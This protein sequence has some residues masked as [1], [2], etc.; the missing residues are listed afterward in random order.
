VKVL[1]RALRYLRPYWAGQM[2]A[3]ICSVIG[4]IL[5]L[6]F[7]WILRIL[8]DQVFVAHG[9]EMAQTLASLKLVCLAFLGISLAS[10]LI[11]TLRA[12]LFTNIGE[13]AVID[14]RRALFEQMERLPLAY[15]NQEKTGRIMSL[16]TNDVGVMQQMYTSTLVDFITN[17]LRVLI[18]LA[19]LFKINVYLAGIALPTLFLFGLNIKLF[20]PPL[21]RMGAQVQEKNAAISENLQESIVGVREVKSLTQEGVQLRRFLEVAWQLWRMRIRQALWGSGSGAMSS[22]IAT[23]GSIL[24]LWLGGNLVIRGLLT[25][26]TLVA[27]STYQM[28]LFG[29]TAWFVNLNVTLQGALAGAERVFAF[30][31]QEPEIQD[32]PGA[33]ELQEVEGWVAFQNVSFSYNG[34]AGPPVLQDITFTARPGQTI[35]LVGPSGAGKSTL[36]NLIPRFYDPQEGTIT[37]DGHDLRAV[38][39]ESLRRQIGQVFQDPFLFGTTI[40]ENIRF[41]RPEATDAEVEAAARAANAH[42]FI[43]R[44]PEGYETSVGE[45]GVKLSGGQLQRIAIA[46]AILRD[47]RILLLDE[48]TSSLDSASEAAVQEALDRL[49]EGRTSFVIAH[50]LSTVLNADCILV[51]DQGR[52]VEAGTHAELLARGGL[53]QKLYQAQFEEKG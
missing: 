50:R 10:S 37:I 2:A 35:A 12:Y 51:L 32:A 34:A 3:L 4:S 19:V 15:F 9:Q 28:Q 17:S 40:R 31:D 36:V 13:R 18:T 23:V 26:G 8:I 38:T 7:P 39:Q 1:W 16:F 42:E 27:F 29:P 46:R 21:R 22:L 24:I 44:F 30:L 25:A 14:L 52:I 33:V 53:Y 20:A 43:V 45:R 49:M 47:P 6:A 11:D 48:A 41:G 5:G